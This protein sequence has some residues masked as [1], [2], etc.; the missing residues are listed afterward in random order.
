MKKEIRII[1]LFGSPFL[2]GS[3]KANID[4]FSALSKYK[5]VKILF[6]IDSKRATDIVKPYL[7]EMSLDYMPV[8]YHFMLRKKMSL[9]EWIVKINEIIT[10]SYQ[11][12]KFYYKFKP[13]HLYVSTPHY[14]LNF[15]P[16]LF[17]LKTPIIYRIGDSPI[18]HNA[19]YRQLWNYMVKK[20]SKIICVSKFIEHQVQMSGAEKSKTEVIYSRP[21]DRKN[22]VDSHINKNNDI[23]NVLY[24]G[25]I[26]KHKGLDLFVEVGVNLCKKYK[27]INFLIAGKVD[28][29]DQFSQA[30][31]DIVNNSELSQR[32]KFL[33]YVS[34]VDD[35]YA[36]SSLHVCPSV[37]DEPLANVL[38]DA[39]KHSMPSI[40][41]D[42]GGLPEII[43]HKVNGYI[44]KEKTALA[45]EKTIEYYFMHQNICKEMG[46][47]AFNSLEE[48]R[49]DKF[50][51]RWLNVFETTC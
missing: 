47:N 13:T 32:V 44:C 30:Q 48:L 41:F 33:D 2:Y 20:V 49:I 29:N 37:Y 51:E 42:V 9:K 16:A 38:I 27:N 46:Q 10:G 25:Q 35:L 6:L 1:V 40:I 34:N 19:L 28:K 26:S 12:L 24:I 11:L 15:F 31:L 43:E 21:H 5:H 7:E 3:E 50:S 18:L 23:F 17:F 39:K 8:N 14:F 22:R 36:S 4:V 45:L